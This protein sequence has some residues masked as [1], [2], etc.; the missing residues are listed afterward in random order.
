MEHKGPVFAPPYEAL[1]KGVK[2]KYNGKEMKLEPI[3]EEIAGFYAHM[4]DH[5][6]V[7]KDVFN[8][9]FFKDWRSQMTPDERKIITDLKKCDFTQ[10]HAY[11]KGT[12]YIFSMKVSLPCKIYLSL[13]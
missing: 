7:T 13:F 5:D 8:A 3:S 6:Y 1:P 9:N 11:F 2:F 12:V 4:L 10:M